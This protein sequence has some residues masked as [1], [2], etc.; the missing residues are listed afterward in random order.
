[1]NPRQ[2]L[3]AVAAL[4]A[5]LSGAA[6]A[7]KAHSGHDD[8]SQPPPPGIGAQPGAAGSGEVF[9]VVLKPARDGGT[10]VYVADIDSNDPI[11]DA[12]IE[13]DTGKTALR[14]EPSGAAGVYRLAWDMPSQPIDLTLTVSAAGRDDLLLVTG[15][16]AAMTPEQPEA[17][18][19]MALLADWRRWL[20]GG[21]ATVAA[22]LGA[23]MILGR[24]AAAGAAIV[25]FSL[26][27]AGSAFAHAGEDHGDGPAPAAPLTVADGQAVVMPKESQFLL[28]VRTARAE[29]REVA[30]TVRLVGRVVPDPAGYARIQPA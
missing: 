21:S 27:A 9:E 2:L 23:T 11:A 6:T 28:Q 1:M 3:V 18:D 14:A 7:A 4:A 8:A 16:A 22:L 29:A 20:T 25:L 13:V 12:T 30:D 15:A 17:A 26:I 19:T 5:A 10:L 24:R